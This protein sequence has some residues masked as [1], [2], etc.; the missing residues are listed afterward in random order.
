MISRNNF[1]IIYYS[2]T[3]EQMLFHGGFHGGFYS[4]EMEEDRGGHNKSRGSGNGYKKDDS[5]E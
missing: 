4:Y 2:I 5:R 3:E 1:F